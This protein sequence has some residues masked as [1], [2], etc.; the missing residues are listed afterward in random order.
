MSFFEKQSELYESTLQAL[1]GFV[2][3]EVP[4]SL[5]RIFDRGMDETESTLNLELTKRELKILFDGSIKHKNALQPLYD[6]LDALFSETSY[7]RMK[8]DF[9]TFG[10]VRKES[11]E[12]KE[13]ELF[14]FTIVRTVIVY[15]RIYFFVLFLFN[16]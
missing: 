3:K 11:K 13:L 1:S 16:V 9:L 6:S 12:I 15:I 2:H 7:A 8:F 10:E 4:S 14:F 5:E